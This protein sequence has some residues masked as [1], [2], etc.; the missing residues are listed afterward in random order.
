MHKFIFSLIILSLF[1]CGP[2]YVDFFPYHDDG[3]PK[4]QVAMTVFAKLQN[5]ENIAILENE[6]LEDIRYVLMDNGELFLISQE[7]T[8]TA[9][10]NI[11]KQALIYQDINLAKTFCDVDFFAVI[12]IIDYQLFPFEC[13]LDA[14]YA[15]PS[16]PNQSVLKM[17][18]R[19]KIYDLRTASPRVVLQ[20]IMENHVIVAKVDSDV[21][22]KKAHEGLSGKI[23][24]RI[25]KIIR[26][27]F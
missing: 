22:L 12:E 9:L 27:T 7:E 19:I 18:A 24:L 6:I 8:E 20:E 23:A 5:Q 17:N 11:D 21:A 2:R 1:G 10:N 25:E 4:P 3:S 14:R 16:Y 26:S 15:L 13:M